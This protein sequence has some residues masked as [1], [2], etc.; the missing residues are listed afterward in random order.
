MTESPCSNKS[1]RALC[2]VSSL[3]EIDP[4]YKS[5]TNVTAPDGDMPIRPL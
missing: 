1:S 5:E 3:S 4:E 2:R